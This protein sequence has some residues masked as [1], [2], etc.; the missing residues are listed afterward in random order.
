[1][2]NEMNIREWLKARDRMCNDQERC[3]DCPASYYCKGYKDIPEE[4]IDIVEQ[5]AAEHPEETL[6][7]VGS[8]IYFD[9]KHRIVGDEYT[10]V[11]TVQITYCGAHKHERNEDGM[12]KA[13]ENIINIIR[14][15]LAN[16]DDVR[17]VRAQQFI[18]KSHEVEC[19]DN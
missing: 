16:A 10:D 5:W 17:C 3:H 6:K 9:P 15:L 13:G 14:P 19:E 7:P 2:K 4:V 1:M 18:T 11:Y 12:R 8:G